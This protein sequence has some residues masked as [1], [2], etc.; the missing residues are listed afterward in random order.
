LGAAGESEFRGVLAPEGELRSE[1]DDD[2]ERRFRIPNGEP[3]V[4]DGVGE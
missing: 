4:I 1:G 3:S 2:D